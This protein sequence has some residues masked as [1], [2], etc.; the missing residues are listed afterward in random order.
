MKL[1]EKI[2]GTIHKLRY[3]NFLVD[4]YYSKKRKELLNKDF[5]ESNRYDKIMMSKGGSV[6][7]IDDA[8]SR[9]PNFRYRHMKFHKILGAWRWKGLWQNKDLICK[10]VFDKSKK[11]IDFGGANGP[12]SLTTTIV[13]FAKK[14]SFHRPVMYNN[15]KDLDFNADFIF[16]SHTLE[17]IPNLDDI[18]KEMKNHLK[19]NAQLFFHVPAYSCS[20]WRS[21]IHTNKAFNDHAWTFCL[22]KDIAKLDFK[23]LLAIDEKVSEYFNLKS[24]KYV[25]DNSIF[26]IASVR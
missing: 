4:N 6:T 2:Q 21:G 14:D 5:I 11:G 19:A 18:F 26:I 17:H 9:S 24:A 13:D 12:I 16:S 1:I 7:S 20:R 10:Y 25:G 22:Q 23:N 3:N 15:L 8:E